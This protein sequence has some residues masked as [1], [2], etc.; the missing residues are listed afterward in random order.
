[1]SPRVSKRVSDDNEG[2]AMPPVR[3]YGAYRCH[4][5][6]LYAAELKEHGVDFILRDVEDDAEA[7]VELRALFGN[8]PDGHTKFPTLLINGKR[9]RNPRLRDLVRILAHEGLSSPGVVHEP[10][11][12]RFVWYMAPRDAFVSYSESDDRITL[13]HI[14]VPPEKRG[15]GL[16]TQLALEVFPLVEAL[17]KTARITCPFIRKV[18]AGSEW[19]SYFNIRTSQGAK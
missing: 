1:M 2:I 11:A 16:G 10:H 15:A 8:D 12:K 19:A 5:T 18:A 17:G 13:G 14:E 3:L 4:K 7:A 6:R 9:V